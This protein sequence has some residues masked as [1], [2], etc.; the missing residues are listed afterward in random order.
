MEFQEIQDEFGVNLS[1]FMPFVN[2]NIKFRTEEALQKQITLGNIH[3]D[4]FT[5]QENFR[6]MFED[7][8]LAN[9]REKQ[10]SKGFE[11]LHKWL[12]LAYR[13]PSSFGVD[14]YGNPNIV[15]SL[16]NPQ[17]NR[18]SKLYALTGLMVFFQV[19][20]DGNHRTAFSYFK[21]NAGREL[22]YKEKEII[23][24]LNRY[25]YSWDNITNASI[26]DVVVE[27]LASKFSS[28]NNLTGGKT[29]RR[30]SKKS[31][32]S[33]FKKSKTSKFKKSKRN[34]FKKSKTKRH[35]KVGKKMKMWKH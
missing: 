2:Q 32:T 21:E 18:L 12:Y 15:K 8:L 10:F 5:E 34:Y 11:R 29:K 25:N 28:M 19:F 27:S 30:K 6:R 1:G 22:T 23:N 33:K 16:N 7:D 35:N 14:K 13:E 26:L 20:G 9:D 31:K 17:I 24:E 4:D 3:I